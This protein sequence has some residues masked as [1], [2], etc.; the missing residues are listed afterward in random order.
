MKKETFGKPLGE[1]FHETKH[2]LVCV[3]ILTLVQMHVR[4][5][6][7]PLPMS[8]YV[9]ALSRTLFVIWA[10]IRVVREQRFNTKQVALV[11]CMMFLVSF[12]AN[13]VSLFTHPII[14]TL[15]I[16]AQLTALGVMAL[17]NLPTSI[18]FALLGGWWAKR[19]ASR[20]AAEQITLTGFL[21]TARWTAAV[22]RKFL[23][24]PFLAYLLLYQ[25]ALVESV[26]YSSTI[27]GHTPLTPTP[28]APTL[29]PIKDLFMVLGL[30]WLVR[31][32]SAGDLKGKGSFLTIAVLFCI[33]YVIQFFLMIPIGL[34]VLFILGALDLLGLP[35]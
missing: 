15:A 30:I 34:V 28:I 27:L 26:S 23:I 13:L 6:G 19:T 25:R 22:A 4:V 3:F 9:L 7:L 17:V 16:S 21:Q 12:M 24:I 8:T 2:L 11:G 20:Q 14:S 29:G 33:T 31:M 10:G 5:L 1:Y 32:R 35:I 18:I